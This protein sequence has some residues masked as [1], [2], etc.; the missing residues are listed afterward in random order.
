[1]VEDGCERYDHSILF[2]LILSIV[3]MEELSYP[4]YDLLPLSSDKTLF[5]TKFLVC[6]PF[7]T[8]IPAYCRTQRLDPSYSYDT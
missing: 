3:M 5:N 7:Y 8:T 6:E 2:A 4:N 1:M